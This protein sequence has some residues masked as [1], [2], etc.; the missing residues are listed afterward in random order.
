[1]INDK[2]LLFIIFSEIMWKST[3]YRSPLATSYEILVASADFLV[4]LAT[5]KA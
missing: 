5:R 2:Q 1:M 4:A 3:N